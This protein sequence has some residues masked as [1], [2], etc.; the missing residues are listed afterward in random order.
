VAKSPVFSSFYKTLGCILKIQ[1]LGFA[2]RWTT[3]FADSWQPLQS[4]ILSH[5]TSLACGSLCQPS[6][7]FP[8]Q[9]IPKKKYTVLLFNNVNSRNFFFLLLFTYGIL[10]AF[11]HG[12]LWYSYS[13]KDSIVQNTKDSNPNG[14][15][16]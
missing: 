11:C 13:Q 2:W 10:I 16:I 12:I 3:D 7:I 6:F 15:A 1:L 5:P 9:H 4:W 8:I 14:R